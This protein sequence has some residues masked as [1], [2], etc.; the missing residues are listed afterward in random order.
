[1]KDKLSAL[2]DGELGDELRRPVFDALKQ[3]SSL[4]TDWNTYCLI[5]DALRGD[6]DGGPDFISRVMAGVGDEATVLAPRPVA[7]QTARRGYWRTLMPLAASL[8]GVAAV[9]WVAHA[10]YAD[11]AESTRVAVSST[12]G[13]AGEVQQVAAAR[14]A[15]AAAA[16]ADP[17]REY[18]FVHQAMTGGG[19]IPGAIQ[20]VRAVSDVPQDGAR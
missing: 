10:L 17:H 7:P 8:M 20:H 18:V 16:A 15:S 12:R 5:G 14:P 1:M 4:R 3:D 13:P 19:P 6:R 11:P 9:G 2:L